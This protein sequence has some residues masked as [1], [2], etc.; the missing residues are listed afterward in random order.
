MQKWIRRSR[1]G[2]LTFAIDYSRAEKLVNGSTEN[3]TK[4]TGMA[5]VELDYPLATDYAAMRQSP[6][7]SSRVERGISF[8]LPLGRR[9]SSASARNDHCATVST[10]AG[11]D[12]SLRLSSETDL[13]K[14]E[15]PR[16]HPAIGD[17]LK[18][19]KARTSMLCRA[20][21]PAGLLGSTKDVCGVKRAG[22]SVS[23]S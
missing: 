2:R 4:I 5:A 13:A 17:Q 10:R 22:P 15:R 11:K 9:D 6:F 7:L 19:A 12:F 23:E 21:A 18:N 14:L 16:S 8:P 3:F 1:Y 20:G